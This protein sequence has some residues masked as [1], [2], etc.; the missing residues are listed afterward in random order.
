MQAMP[1]SLDD[2]ILMK[3]WVHAD[4]PEQRSKMY[5]CFAGYRE[6]ILWKGAES[7]AACFLIFLIFLGFCPILEFGRQSVE[8]LN[9][10]ASS[11]LM[12]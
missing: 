2:F 12:T 1:P 8:T 11:V 6:G 4:P 10:V 7:H 3:A 9:A 5:Q